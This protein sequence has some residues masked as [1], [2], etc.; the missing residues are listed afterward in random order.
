MRGGK[1]VWGGGKGCVWEG[2]TVD[3]FSGCAY[4]C[5]SACFSSVYVCVRYLNP[6]FGAL[7]IAF[8]PIFAPTA[9]VNT[10]V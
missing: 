5:R 3:L 8:P 4:V 1:G 2:K 10:C 7:Q 6:L 9:W